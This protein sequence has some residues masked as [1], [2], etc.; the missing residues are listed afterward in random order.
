MRETSIW[1]QL[2]S[3]SLLR[4]LGASLWWRMV[5]RVTLWL[6]SGVVSYGKRSWEFTSITNTS[7]KRM[8]FSETKPLLYSDS[9]T[10][11]CNNDC[12]GLEC[13][14]GSIETNLLVTVITQYST[15]SL[16]SEYWSSIVHTHCWGLNAN[17]SNSSSPK[18]RQ[19][20][21]L[22]NDWFIGWYRPKSLCT[23]T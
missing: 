12:W 7:T 22:V 1:L 18:F 13:K 21:P 3:A 4:F 17:L 14:L 16:S 19:S 5:A 6:I 9:H 10:W 11:H 2:W 8:F 20:P 15:K 23:C